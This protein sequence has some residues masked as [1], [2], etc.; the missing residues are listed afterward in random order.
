MST[1]PGF[2]KRRMVLLMVSYLAVGTF[3]CLFVGFFKPDMN[4]LLL[5]LIVALLLAFLSIYWLRKNIFFVDNPQIQK[6]KFL[7]TGIITCTIL[8]FAILCYGLGTAWTLAT[9]TERIVAMR[10]TEKS[11]GSPR[12][13]HCDFYVKTEGVTEKIKFETCLSEENWSRVSVGNIINFRVKS[14]SLGFINN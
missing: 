6:T 4:F 14:T 3:S 9:G 12:R 10:I 8:W 7:F 2:S 11:S 13:K 5:C 1:S